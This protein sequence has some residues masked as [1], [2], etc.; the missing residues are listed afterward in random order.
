MRL[1][2]LGRAAAGPVDVDRI[3]ADLGVHRHKVL[4]AAGGLRE[5]GLL[6]EFP[7]AR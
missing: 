4:K 5:G 7:G 1:A 6:T 2:I 3:A